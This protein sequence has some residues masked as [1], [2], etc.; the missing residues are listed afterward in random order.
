MNIWDRKIKPLNFQ[1]DDL[2]YVF[3]VIFKVRIVDLLWSEKVIL[4]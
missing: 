2:K 3:E 1:W 4:C